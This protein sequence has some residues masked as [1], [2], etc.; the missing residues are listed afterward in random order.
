MGL[1]P[2]SAFALACNVLQLIETGVKVLSKT[3]DYRSS[4]TGVLTE[5]KDLHDIL[6]SLYNVNSDLQDSLSAPKNAQVRTLEEVRLS[7]ANVQ[8]LQL[9]RD[10]LGF[11]DSLK[12]KDKSA[13]LGSFRMSVKS[14]WHRDKMTAM[15][16]ALAQA[17]DNL[18]VNLLVYM[19]Y[20]ATIR[21]LDS[22]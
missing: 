14:L 4:E 9:S 7:E 18:N 16:K 11:L 15:E 19:K 8:C 3:A 10:F 2:L 22:R 13:V 5:Q 6:Q 1:D 21:C 17:R 12:L 20:A